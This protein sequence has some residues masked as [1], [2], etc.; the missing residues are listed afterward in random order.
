MGAIGRFRRQ[1]DGGKD[2]KAHQRIAKAKL[3]AELEAKMNEAMAAAQKRQ[4]ER[5]LALARA[6]EALSNDTITTPEGNEGK[7][8]D[9]KP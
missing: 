2:I 3:R 1:L 9:T 6:M 7:V 4:E 5:A 8:L